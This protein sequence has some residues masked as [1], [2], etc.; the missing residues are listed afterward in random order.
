MRMRTTLVIPLPS[1]LS[2]VTVH[3]GAP[4]VAETNGWLVTDPRALVE[5]S[6]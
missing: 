5:K 3:A 6:I 2:A 1:V 4:P